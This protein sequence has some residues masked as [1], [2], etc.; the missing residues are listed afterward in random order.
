MKSFGFSLEY[1]KYTKN[2]KREIRIEKDIDIDDDTTFS[3]VSDW[4]AALKSAVAEAVRVTKKGDTFCFE[5]TRGIYENWK[6]DKPLVQK[7]FDA[8]RGAYLS[9]DEEGVYLPP[10]T[11]Y[12]RE[13]WDLYLTPKTLLEDIKNL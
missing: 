10:N 4:L 13:T 8:W 5:L 12:T 9:Q 6:S 11:K 3:E 1:T 7:S 2:G